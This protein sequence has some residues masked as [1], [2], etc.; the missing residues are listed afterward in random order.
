MPI[1]LQQH[2]EQIECRDVPCSMTPLTRNIV[3]CSPSRTP[4]PPG[5]CPAAGR[6]F[7]ADPILERRE[8]GEIRCGMIVEIAC[9]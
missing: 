1:A 5:T 6:G 3:I 2:R 4:R 7:S 9:L 8:V